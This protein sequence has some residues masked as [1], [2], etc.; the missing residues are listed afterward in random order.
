MKKH[1]AGAATLLMSLILVMV[2]T[3]LMVFAANYGTLMSRSTANLLRGAQAYEAA[4]AGL[5]FGVAYLINNKTTITAS[6]ISGSINYGAAI[7]S[8]NVT[9][10]NNSSFAVR[11]T[12]PTPFNVSLIQIT[13]KIGRAHV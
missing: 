5:E 11:Y 10:A 7:G 9:L 4:Q 8:L 12:N 3:L 6:A 13:S 2:V 1:S